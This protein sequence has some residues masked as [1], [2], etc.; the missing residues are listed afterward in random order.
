MWQPLYGLCCQVA[1]ASLLRVTKRSI[2]PTLEV[3]WQ[4]K[5]KGTTECCFNMHLLKERG[6]KGHGS[7]LYSLELLG[8]YTDDLEETE[9]TKPLLANIQMLKT[10]MYCHIMF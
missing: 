2:Y 1:H 9:G 3:L 6:N 5:K 8:E 4:K 10:G 7:H